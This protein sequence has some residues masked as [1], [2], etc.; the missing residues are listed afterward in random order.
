MSKEESSRRRASA[1]RSAILALLWAALL[2]TLPSGAPAAGKKRPLGLSIQKQA[3]TDGEMGYRNYLLY[4][5]AQYDQSV[6]K[7][8]PLILFLHGSEQRGDDPK[9]VAQEG[10]PALVAHDAS[11]P[12][13]VVSP[14]CPA[15]AKWS[16]P[17]L[18]KLLGTVERKLRIDSRRVYLTGFSMGGYG[19]WR[20]AAA[21]PEVFAAIAPVCGGGDP[22]TAPRLTRVPVWAFHGALDE[23]VPLS[24]SRQMV[25]AVKRDGGRARLTIYP[26]LEHDSWTR[27]YKNPK[28]YAWFLAHKK[29]GS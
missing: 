28:L 1:F 12:F 17:A 10:L 20:T 5:P 15:D 24:E 7:K 22:E 21:Y 29:N 11:F 27:T 16:P 14:Q 6:T 8:W 23:N 18:L 25:D 26:D 2:L 13:I 9:L 3:I 19:T 4:L